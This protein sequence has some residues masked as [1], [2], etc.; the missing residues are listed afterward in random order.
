[1]GAC[2]CKI[3]NGEKNFIN[4]DQIEN[5]NQIFNKVNETNVQKEIIK[6]QNITSDSRPY[7]GAQPHQGNSKKLKR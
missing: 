3:L 2:G 4:I 7:I 1:M 5:N 6:S